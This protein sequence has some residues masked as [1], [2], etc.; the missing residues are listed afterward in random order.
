MCYCYGTYK[1]LL[2]GLGLEVMETITTLFNAFNQHGDNNIYR[3][4]PLVEV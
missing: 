2:S 3:L 4:S 1:V